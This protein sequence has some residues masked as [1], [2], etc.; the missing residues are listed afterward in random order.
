MSAPLAP[1]HYPAIP[2]LVRRSR[3]DI[4]PA[5]LDAQVRGR[6]VLRTSIPAGPRHPRLVSSAHGALDRLLLTVPAYAAGTVEGQTNPIAAAYRDLIAALPDTVRYT[7]VTHDAVA[8][9][10]AGWFTGCSDPEIIA[11]PDH[12][13]FSVWAEDGYVV[14][15]DA[16][17]ETFLIEPFEFPRYGDGLIADFVSNATAL[18]HTQ[19][20]LYF[21]GGNVLIGDDFFLIGA[22]YPAK[23]LGYLNRVL[24]PAP[25][26]A[27]ADAIHRLYREHL[28]DQRS[29][30]FVG[31]TV[32]VPTQTT[33]QIEIDGE[34]WTEVLH[35]GN[36]QGTVQPLF[37]ID[38]FLTL[39]GRDAHGRYRIVVGDPGLAA[40]VLGVPPWP[41][42]MQEVFDNIAQQL[43]D[44]GFAVTR[45]PLPLV[46]V[47]DPVYRERQWY[48]ATA[49]NALVEVGDAG[50]DRVWLPA[51]GFGAWEELSATD[52]ANLDVWRG[53]G[54]EATLLAD[55]HPFAA[56]LGAVH[57]ITKYLGR[58]LEE[59][60]MPPV[61][62]A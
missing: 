41:H 1:R 59:E 61:G 54:F 22:D 50:H 60:G 24:I 7:V 57:C 46:Y 20:P 43:R 14:A 29:L 55:F 38:M 21:Q 62:G 35:L 19:A 31:S 37:H 3:G 16:A 2:G 53:L 39:A 12:L 25:G 45:N 18:S 17:G 58:G 15:R 36:G 9:E 47:D 6:A 23:S 11:A 5:A 30:H 34:L 48:F 40:S 8:D 4:D 10:V 51:Y 42:A 13:H 26:E 33:R 56:N 52:A 44:L 28:D 32:P 27:P 49:N